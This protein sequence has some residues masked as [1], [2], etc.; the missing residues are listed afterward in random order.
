MSLDD[1]P[2]LTDRVREQMMEVYERISGEAAEKC[3][4][5]TS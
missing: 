3:K 1:V 2:L 4:L 5:K